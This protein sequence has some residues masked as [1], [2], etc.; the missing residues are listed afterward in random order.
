VFGIIYLVLGSSM[1]NSKSL[2]QSYDLAASWKPVRSKHRSLSKIDLD[3]QQ[4]K[5]H[6]NTSHSV[7]LK[8]SKS[9]KKQLKDKHFKPMEV[10]FDLVDTKVDKSFDSKSGSREQ[11]NTAKEASAYLEFTKVDVPKEKHSYSKSSRASFRKE[12]SFKA[13]Y[14]TCNTRDVLGK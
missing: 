12:G 13:N 8:L 14:S 5:Y 11:G 3:V 7:A 1:I 10:S 9:M 6:I 2:R 4:S